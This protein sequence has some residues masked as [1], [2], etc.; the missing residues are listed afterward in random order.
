MYDPK[1]MQADIEWENI[2]YWIQPTHPV[3]LS[4]LECFQENGCQLV[5]IG[6]YLD[7]PEGAFLEITQKLLAW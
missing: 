6:L 3:P 1:P 5:V 7:V 4:H 2:C